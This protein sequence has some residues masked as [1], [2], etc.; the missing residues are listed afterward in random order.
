MKKI[1]SFIVVALAC[2]SCILSNVDK[3]NKLIKDVLIKSL[4]HAD[5]YDPVETILD[6][7]FTPFDSPEFYEKT[8]KVCKLGMEIEKYDRLSQSE[9]STMSIYSGS[10]MSDYSRNK[11]NEA[12]EKYTEYNEKKIVLEKKFAKLLKEI[13]SFVMQKPQFIGIKAKHRYRAQTNGGMIVFGESKFLFDKNL[14]HI[15][16]HWDMDDAEYKMVQLIYKK[17]RGED[18]LEEEFAS[19]EAEFLNE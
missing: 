14:S 16:Y 2:A 19:I 12:K 5:S 10:Y 1:L 13:K 4:Y 6:S 3:A 15:V 18:V 11:Y 17:M 8:L 7:A 9:K